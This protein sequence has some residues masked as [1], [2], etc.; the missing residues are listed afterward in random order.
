M[1]LDAVPWVLKLFLV[2]WSRYGSHDAVIRVLKQFQVSWCCSLKQ[3]Q[4]SWWCFLIHETV[5][6][7]DE[8]TWVLIQFQV[9]WCCSLSLET[10]LRVLKLF[11]ESWNISLSLDAEPWSLEKVPGGL[12]M[13]LVSWKCSWCLHIFSLSLETEL[14]VLMFFFKSLSP[15][16]YVLPLTDS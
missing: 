3:F 16:S 4:E 15:S 7:L 9:F 5:P 1:R 10:D 13:F 2:S 6:G 14:R 11:L 12:K 8:V